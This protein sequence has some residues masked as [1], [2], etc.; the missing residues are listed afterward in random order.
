MTALSR[1]FGFLSDRRWYLELLLF[2]VVAVGVKAIMTWVFK[3]PNS[4]T[5]SLVWAATFAIVVA[6]VKALSSPKS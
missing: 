3:R 1:R 6:V 4:I 5:E 2:F